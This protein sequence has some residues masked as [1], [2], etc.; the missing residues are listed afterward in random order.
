MK[1]PVKKLAQ[2]LRGTG[3]LKKLQGLKSR[4]G[5]LSRAWGVLL[6][7]VLIVLIVEAGG[8]DAE[9]AEETP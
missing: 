1:A 5:F 8:G 4:R 7:I 3:F 2:G 9:A 6:L